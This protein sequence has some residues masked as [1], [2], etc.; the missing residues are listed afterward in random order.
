MPSRPLTDGERAI[1]GEVFRDALDCDRVRV[2]HRRWLPLVQPRDS[3]MAPLGHLYMHGA[4]WREDYSEAT[5]GMRAV[6][7]HEMTHVWQWQTGVC[8]PLLAGAW[9]MLRTGF[10]YGRA[11]A[12]EADPAKDLLDYNL[13]QQA[14]I[15]EDWYAG[16]RDAAM[17]AVLRRFRK[18]PAYPRIARP[19]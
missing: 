5:L 12:Y 17:A 16:R 1:A 9:Q 6:F 3:G 7:V 2:H 19:R 18:D 15:V 10:R 13:E 11:Y 14:R 4:F 8:V